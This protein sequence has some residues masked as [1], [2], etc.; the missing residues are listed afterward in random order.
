MPCDRVVLPCCGC[1]GR[2]AA[3][4]KQAWAVEGMY[5]SEKESAK[6]IDI[7]GKWIRGAATVYLLEQSVS[8]VGDDQSS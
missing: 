5:C 2:S 8:G 1:D 6:A 7:L 3:G 4:G